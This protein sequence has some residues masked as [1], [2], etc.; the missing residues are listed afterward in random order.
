MPREEFV[1]LKTED[2]LSEKGGKELINTA[3]LDNQVTE[4][5]IGHGAEQYENTLIETESCFIGLGELNTDFVSRLSAI[6]E[7]INA[8]THGISQLPPLIGLDKGWIQEQQ[9]AAKVCISD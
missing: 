8:V 4:E 3:D 6:S 1:K 5:I 2:E 9:N 7:I